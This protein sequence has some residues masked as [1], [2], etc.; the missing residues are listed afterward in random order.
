[1]NPRAFLVVLLLAAPSAAPAPALAACA[2]PPAIAHRGGTEAFPENT[3]EAF[4]W[5]SDTAKAAWWETD[6]Q[7]DVTDVPYIL[8]DPT[9]DRM[10]N[11][12]GPVSEH[13]LAADRAA[14]LRV[15]GGY[16]VPSLYELLTDAKGRAVQVQVELKSA[17]SAVQLS[18]FLARLDWTGMR[19]RV[20]VTSFSTATLDAVRAAAEVRTGLVAELG[21]Q[22]PADVLP[23]AEVLAKHHW[24]VTAA[25][26]AKWRGAGLSVT[27]WTPDTVE[28]WKRMAG[29]GPGVIAGVTTNKPNAYR[30]ADVC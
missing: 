3:R 13:D 30:L 18:R 10:T 25:R 11:G 14:G 12:T 19:D 22:D 5:A 29:Y 7:F 16:V 23:H 17:P 6:V 9:L 8:H 27:T 28:T 15:D 4:R 21:D 24:A 2:K 20:V 26:L 1:M